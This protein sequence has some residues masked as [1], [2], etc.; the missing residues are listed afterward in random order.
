MGTED[1]MSEF[2]SDPEEESQVNKTPEKAN[3]ADDTDQVGNMVDGTP[4]TAGVCHGN[5]GPLK[6]FGPGPIFSE[7]FGPVGPILSEKKGPCPEKKVQRFISYVHVVDIS[8]RVMAEI[9]ETSLEERQKILL[10]CHIDST[11]GHMGKTRTL[12]RIKERFMWHGMVKDVVSLLSKCD[13]CQRMNRKLTTGVPELHPIPV[14]APW[15]MVGIDFIGPLSSVAKDGSRYILTISDYFTKWVEVIFMRMGLPRVLLSDNGSEFCNALN[16]QLSEMLGIK[17]RLTTPYHPQTLVPFAYNTSRHDSTKYTPFMLM[18][19]HRATLPIDVELEQQCSEDLCKTYWEL[20]EHPYPA[21]FSEHARILEEA[22]GNII[23]A[24]L[25]QKEAYD[26]KHCK[27]GQFLCNQLVLLRN[28]S[29]KKVKGG[30]LTERFLGPYTIINVLQNGVYEIR[31]E[32]GK[33]TRATGSHLKMYMSSDACCMEDEDEDQSSSQGDCVTPSGTLASPQSSEDDSDCHKGGQS[34]AVNVATVQ[35]QRGSDDCGVFAIAFA[36][37]AALGH[38]KEEIEFDQATMRDH[39]LKCYTTRNFTPFPT[40]KVKRAH[41]TLIMNIDVFCSCQMPDT[42]GD[43]DKDLVKWVELDTQMFAMEPPKASASSPSF[44]ESGELVQ[45]AAVVSPVATPPDPN[46]ITTTISLPTSHTPNGEW[47]AVPGELGPISDPSQAMFCNCPPDPVLPRTMGLQNLKRLQMA[48][49]YSVSM[50]GIQKLQLCHG[51]GGGWIGIYSNQTT[52]LVMGGPVLNVMVTLTTCYLRGCLINV[53]KRRQ[54]YS[55]VEEIKRLQRDA[56]NF[57]PPRTAELLHSVYHLTPDDEL[58]SL[59]RELEPKMVVHRRATRS[60]SSTN[61]SSTTPNIS[62]F[63]P[64]SKHL[65][66]TTL[67]A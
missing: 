22:K 52:P 38:C 28:F 61:L 34:K 1:S 10:A 60:R 36:L 45:N 9:E 50:S 41:H 55:K 23:A 65:S 7:N 64:N 46:I 25:R 54:V 62:F 58:H 27:P 5:F 8:L 48:A 11:S 13:V 17:R 4:H 24:Q 51:S 21:V 47:G 42:Y 16:D 32:E 14:K 15:Y 37:H 19:G 39:L 29:C 59:S 67:R 35:K 49:V 33:T 43:M 30:K 56:Y 6:N 57:Q 53:H 18:F 26:K 40:K 20:E 44:A 31:N 3:E 63:K 2:S 66:T 12:Y